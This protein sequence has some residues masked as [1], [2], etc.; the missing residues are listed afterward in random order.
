MFTLHGYREASSDREHV[1]LCL[2]DPAGDAVLARLHSECLT[3]ESFGSMRC[4]CQPQLE[5][6]MARVAREGRGVIVYLR[7]HEGRGIGLLEKLR[8]YALQDEGADTVEANL[9]LGLPVDGRDYGVGVA[10]LRDLGVCSV[11][12]MTNNPRKVE[13]VLR[14]GLPVNERVPLLTPVHEANRAYLRTKQLMLGHQLLDG[15]PKA[16]NMHV[17]AAFAPR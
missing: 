7:G 16:Q 8:A 13:Q 1:A 9:R 10:M 6:A 17:N 5:T 11:R 12:L 2:G 3:G 14:S 4:D 15:E